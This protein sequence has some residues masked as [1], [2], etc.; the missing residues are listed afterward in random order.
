MT[1]REKFFEHSIRPETILHLGTMM[2][3]TPPESLKKAFEY[4]GDDVFPLLG[5]DEE[6]VFGYIGDHDEDDLLKALADVKAT[7]WLV[8][9]A[10]PVP[11]DFSPDGSSWSQSWGFYATK[12]IY[13]NSYN[14]CCKLAIRWANEYVNRARREFLSDASPEKTK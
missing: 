4:D 6:G 2:L 12:W 7:G 13:G 10:T 5:I 3:E 1:I 14:A 8:K 9:F 11:Q